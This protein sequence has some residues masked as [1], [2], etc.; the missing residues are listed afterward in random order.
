MTDPAKR[1]SRAAE[2]QCAAN[3]PAMLIKRL[4]SRPSTVDRS[5]TGSCADR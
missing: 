5:K 4:R 1:E 2:G 3:V